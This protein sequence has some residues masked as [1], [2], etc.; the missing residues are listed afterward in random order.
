[1]D[2]FA[3]LLGLKEPDESNQNA[4]YHPAANIVMIGSY[5]FL[6]P[7]NQFRSSGSNKEKQN[8]TIGIRNSIATASNDRNVVQP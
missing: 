6:A 3:F 7:L 2:L 5:P 4:A 8:D 1:M